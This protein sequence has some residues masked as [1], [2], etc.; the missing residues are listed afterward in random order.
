MNRDA[1]TYVLALLEIAV[2]FV[3]CCRTC[4]MPVSVTLP[5]RS[6]LQR[7][8]KPY[9]LSLAFRPHANFFMFLVSRSISHGLCLGD[10]LRSYLN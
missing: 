7:S 5:L 9:N 2:G 4:D 3:A 8:T 1:K 6:D 10:L